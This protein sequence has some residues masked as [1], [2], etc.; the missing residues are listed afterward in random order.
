M[1]QVLMKAVIMTAIFS[2]LLIIP[3][4]MTDRVHADAMN[5][6]IVSRY[7]SVWNLEVEKE[8]GG[9]V[10][11]NGVYQRT[12]TSFHE[13]QGELTRYF[14][15]ILDTKDL[16]RLQA[17]FDDKHEIQVNSIRDTAGVRISNEEEAN[18]ALEK[19]TMHI[20]TLKSKVEQELQATK[21]P[22]TLFKFNSSLAVD[23][24]KKSIRKINKLIEH[25]N[26]LKKS[27]QEKDVAAIVRYSEACC[28]EDRIAFVVTWVL[29]DTSF[30][31]ILS[32]EFENAQTEVLDAIDSAIVV[33]NQ[34]NDSKISPAVDAISDYRSSISR[35]LEMF[36][37][38]RNTPK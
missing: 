38:A 22:L 6:L 19:V 37:D 21:S 23:L 11:D 18:A 31:P 12:K 27:I 20:S 1:N 32:R 28:R 2:S 7:L 5:D 29:Q 17:I 15:S 36:I 25:T 35:R 13:D 30:Y 9:T 3:K 26:L 4:Y 8:A 34:K 24:Q 16:P 33:L 10:C 14:L